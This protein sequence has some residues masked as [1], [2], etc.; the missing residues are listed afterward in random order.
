LKLFHGGSA[1]KTFELLRHYNLFQYLFPLT[2]EALAHE[3][4][5]FPITLVPR[6]LENT[7]LR[8]N[9][10][11]PVTPA[12]LFAA[13]LWEPARLRLREFEARGLNPY[14]ALMAAADEVMSTQLRHV[15]IPKRFSLPMR[16]IWA[17]QNKFERRSGKQAQR[18]FEH[19]RFRAAY[20]FL[21]LRAE[22]GE[23]SKD[24]AHWW[25]RFQEVDETERGAMVAAF[26]SE[27]GTKK[28]R[29]RRRRRKK[30]APEAPAA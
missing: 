8:V 18:L 5:H 19:P 24:L 23:A 28:K 25:T 29:R 9:Q 10:D 17:L 1:L 7:D 13:L 15:A 4:R 27:E 3:F 20:D 16:E 26:G 6:A 2:E 21:L 30:S 14:D 12:F 22:T 11:K